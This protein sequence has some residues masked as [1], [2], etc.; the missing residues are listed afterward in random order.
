MDLRITTQN[1]QIG[2]ET[3]NGQFDI[4]QN[5]FPMDLS[6]K[7]PRLHLQSEE[8][9]IYIDQRRCFSEAGLKSSMELT[10][11]YAQKGKQAALQATA[12]IASEGRELA[13]I[14]AKGSAIARQAKRKAATFG[15]KEFNFD[16]IP[17]SRPE[18]TVKPGKVHGDFEKGNVDIQLKNFR[19]EIYYQR[20]DVEIYLKQKNYISFEY[21]GKGIDLLGG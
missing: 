18:I 15:D 19:P 1:A 17:K 5:H 16:M 21:V 13:N 12:K 10:Q 9:V 3:A 6:T 4:R 20:G 7:E 2:I 8:A 11:K 14:Q